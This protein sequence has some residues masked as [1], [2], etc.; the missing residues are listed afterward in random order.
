MTTVSVPVER[1][2]RLQPLRALH[3]LRELVR[4]PADTERV[5]HV[6]DALRGATAERNLARLERLRPELIERGGNILD[7]LCDRAGLRAMPADSLGRAY[8]GFCER[9]GIT[10]E[11]L[12]EASRAAGREDGEG[13]GFWLQR[14]LRDTHDL[15]HV[16]TGYGTD[17]RG[18]VNVVAF[19]F[20]QTGHLG[21][22]AIAVAGTLKH[23]GS[24]GLRRS[25][26]TTWQAYRTGRRAAWLPAQDWAGLLV[27]PLAEVRMRLG[28]RMG[29]D[30]TALRA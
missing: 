7:V 11:G 1:A 12:V 24:A 20:A 5:F 23:A 29:E 3:A 21:F 13:A 10:P 9:E 2:P 4:N 19:S 14:R 18:E 17:P 16:V 6:M 15:W 26:A 28:L 27:R 8:L 25:A 22:A 30:D